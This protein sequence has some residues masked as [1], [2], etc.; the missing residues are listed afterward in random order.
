[1]R[2]AQDAIAALQAA[3]EETEK[4]RGEL[5][6]ALAL[7]Q[8][9][10]K[11]FKQAEA[12][13]A[14]ER[15]VIESDRVKVKEMRKEVQRVSKANQ[16]WGMRLLAEARRIDEKREANQAQLIKERQ[17]FVLEQE[18]TLRAKREAEQSIAVAQ[19]EA[20]L[21]VTKALENQRLAEQAQQQAL[22]DKAATHEKNL[23][24]AHTLD[25]LTRK[26]STAESK[27]TTKKSELATLQEQLDTLQS[28]LSSQ[29]SNSQRGY[30]LARTLARAPVDPTPATPHTRS[31]NKR[32]RNQWG[33]S[34][35]DS[36]LDTR[37]DEE[38]SLL[39]GPPRKKVSSGAA[40][41]Q[42]QGYD[43]MLANLAGGGAKDDGTRKEVS[44]SSSTHMPASL[45]ARPNRFSRTMAP[46]RPA[47]P[48][49]TAPSKA[50]GKERTGDQDP[51]Q[52][53]IKLDESEPPAE[54]PTKTQP[55]AKSTHKPASK[56]SANSIRS[57]LVPR[58]ENASDEDV[59]R[60]MRQAVA[61]NATGS[62]HKVPSE[63]RRI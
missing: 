9:G 22:D 51:F 15:T 42:E 6:Q 23:R 18:S 47:R 37:S 20:D 8:D 57:F 58:R 33:E 32:D 4:V 40:T 54:P 35:D 41:Q 62:R 50:K 27:L 16:E 3:M 44:T 1:M 5:R 28:Q 24:M 17:A 7:S 48:A 25:R 30:P 43:F 49:A 12:A 31:H 14:A 10:K 29:R 46:A 39:V 56:S 45:F 55:I 13:V 36:V 38:S 11:L 34:D 59:S 19:R 61:G 53:G 26:L 52:G 21:K 63:R 60:Y 2:H